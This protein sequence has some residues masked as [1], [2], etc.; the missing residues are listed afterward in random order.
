MTV[1]KLNAT[2]STNDYLRV[3]CNTQRVENYTTVTAEIQTQ[4]KGQRGNKWT[5][6]PHKNLTFSILIQDVLPE[7]ASV[8]DLNIAV[9]TALISA[10]E[11]FK[12][13]KISIK[14]PNDI[15]ADGKKIAGILIENSISGNHKVLSIVGVGVNVNQ[16]DFGNL[17]RASSLK[18]S[19]QT[20]F[21]K[22]EI[23]YQIIDE[24][25]KNGELIRLGK[26]DVLW[27]KYHE[28]LFRKGIPSVFENPDGTKFMGIIKQVLKNG[29][30]QLLLE[31]D[32]LK[33]F[34]LKEIGL[35][36]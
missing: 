19:T 16:T 15:L 28:Y 31:D 34:E 13:P 29:K 9:S 7:N 17:P 36:Y 18:N 8:F 23:L 24:I 32:S 20:T 30:L 3:L 12:I 26:A 25:K 6:E 27:K 10:L 1:I 14:W 21:D 33:E 5:T 2:A 35:V 11:S 4:G 22:D